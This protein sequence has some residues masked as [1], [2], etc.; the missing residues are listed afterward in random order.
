MRHQASAQEQLMRKHQ[1]LPIG[2]A[3]QTWFKKI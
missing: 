3:T 1:A 2:E